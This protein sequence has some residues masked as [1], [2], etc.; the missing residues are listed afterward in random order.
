MRIPRRSYA[1]KQHSQLGG[2]QMN[3]P[4]TDHRPQAQAVSISP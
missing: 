4:V 2:R 1:L 3:F